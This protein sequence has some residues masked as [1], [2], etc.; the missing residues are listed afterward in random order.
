MSYN[1]KKS[2]G[3]PLN[4][5][6]DGGVDRIQTSL[7]LVGPNYIGYGELQNENFVFLLENF[8]NDAPPRSPV[9]GQ[10]WYDTTAAK[11]RYFFDGIESTFVG[12]IANSTAPDHD[13]LQDGD[14]WWDTSVPARKKLRA[15]NADS[16]SFIEVGPFTPS[17]TNTGSSII[18]VL[19]A[20]NVSREVIRI[21]DESGTI[22]AI[23]SRHSQFTVNASDPIQ[24][25]F[26]TIRP[27]YN[28]NTTVANNA[29]TG[30][31]NN[32][33]TFNSSGTG[34]ASG[35]SYDNLA[36][37]TI[38]YNTIGAQP[39]LV[40]GTNIK[41]INGT[42]IL[43]SGNIVVGSGD[44]NSVAA[45]GTVSGITLS[46]TTTSGAVSITLDGTL[47]VA[48][49]A[50]GT[51]SANRIL[52]GPASGSSQNPTFRALV[53]ADIPNSITSNTSGKAGSVNNT[54]NNGTLNFW[55]GTQQQYDQ[56]DP[57]LPTTLYFITG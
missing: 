25:Q 53:S 29:Y 3:D 21:S 30:K 12:V 36:A 4:E 32:S 57:K 56:V 55:T 19:D 8:A 43:G 31:V 34:A 54:A 28:L 48:P 47:S 37:I 52:A 16:G 44:I 22:I 10:L 26:S 27:G 41:T 18:N 39:L 1:I 50:F 11:L 45:S 9:A 24:A 42:S 38:S 40:S 20:G 23:V 46:S 51:Q 35:S 6:V 15:Y 33:I 49:S 7:S 2:N 13:G 17:E 14:L 5:I